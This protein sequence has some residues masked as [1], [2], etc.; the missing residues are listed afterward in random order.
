MRLPDLPSS[1]VRTVP[2]NDRRTELLAEPRATHNLTLLVITNDLDVATR[3]A[4]R[5]IPLTALDEALPPPQS[6]TR[7][8]RSVQTTSKRVIE[9]LSRRTSCGISRS[10]KSRTISSTPSERWRSPMPPCRAAVPHP[11]VRSAMTRR[12]EIAKDSG[13]PYR[14]IRSGRRLPRAAPIPM[15]S[16]SAATVPTVEPMNVPVRPS[17]VTSVRLLYDKGCPEDVGDLV[18]CR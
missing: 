14:I 11:R 6:L 9:R 5:S 1:N 7:P 16:S 17:V 10:G 13:A 4:D 2:R 15:A 3:L 12:P 8:D 18:R